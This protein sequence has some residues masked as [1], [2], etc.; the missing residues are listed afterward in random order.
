MLIHS[1]RRGSSLSRWAFWS[2]PQV[3]LKFKSN[4]LLPTPFRTPLLLPAAQSMHN[5]TLAPGAQVTAPF[6]SRC[7][8]R[9]LKTMINFY[10]VLFY[11]TLILLSRQVCR[12]LVQLLLSR[13][14]AESRV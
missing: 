5:H 10:L 9:D 11:A 14:G 13:V 3:P 8:E 2:D 7:L 1:R 6:P 12:L 4:C